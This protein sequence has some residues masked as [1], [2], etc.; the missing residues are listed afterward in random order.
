ME[1]DPTIVILSAL[2]VL[3]GMF[4]IRLELRINRLLRGSD[5]KTLEGTIRVVEKGHREL[6]QFRA[7][8]E[9]YLKNVEKRLSRSIQ[10]IETIRFNPFKGIGLG[11]NQSFSTVFLDERGDG[12]IVSSL[13]ARDRMSIF[14]KPIKKNVSEFEL[15]DEEKMVLTKA[16]NILS[17]K[18]GNR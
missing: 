16:A 3:L 17:E 1:L 6:T 9:K 11:G 10:S 12:V 13:Y 14:S 4:V 5:N 15:T 8:V 2:L 18:N 7:E